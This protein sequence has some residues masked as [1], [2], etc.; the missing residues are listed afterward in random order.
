M[1]VVAV[2][3][4]TFIL[5]CY[6]CVPYYGITSRWRPFWSRKGGAKEY[7]NKC[8]RMPQISTS[9]TG[10]QDLNQSAWAHSARAGRTGRVGRTG[11]KKR[12][13]TRASLRRYST[14][15]PQATT[16]WLWPCTPCGVSV[17]LTSVCVASSPFA[18]C[19]HV[20][21]TSVYT[22]QCYMAAMFTT[23]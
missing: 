11:T 10:C 3:V 8:S 9:L 19:M 23:L 6:S 20:A 18:Y 21:L 13:R 17:V 1:P 15:T 14:H 2:H 22:S 5:L 4:T 7:T 12:R 16:G